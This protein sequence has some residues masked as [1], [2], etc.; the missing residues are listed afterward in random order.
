MN[1]ALLFISSEVLDIFR[2]RP[3]PQHMIQFQPSGV[4]KLMTGFS[5]EEK[6]PGG[7]SFNA[8]ATLV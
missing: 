3:L 2:R 1:Q 4:V 5:V 8:V 6:L 7:G